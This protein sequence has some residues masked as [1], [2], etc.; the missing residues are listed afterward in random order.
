MKHTL[1]LYK[2]FAG[3]FC[4]QSQEKVAVLPKDLRPKREVRCLAPLLVNPDPQSKRD[5]QNFDDYAPWKFF[6][7]SVLYLGMSALLVER[8]PSSLCNCHI[9]WDHEVGLE[10]IAITVQPDGGIY[11]QGRVN[12]A[13][14][15]D[16]LALN[17]AIFCA[18][19]IGYS[20]IV[21]Y[22][23]LDDIH[24]NWPL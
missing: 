16:L 6:N 9:C 5:D 21:C 18:T 15:V 8:H 19:A 23:Y 12:P 3:E 14:F 10:S 7:G 11:V 13:M 20:G 1:I 4:K 2:H 22:E 24:D 17:L